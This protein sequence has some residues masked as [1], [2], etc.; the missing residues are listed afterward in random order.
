M[1]DGARTR[2]T[3]VQEQTGA[4]MNV[5]AESH[6]AEQVVKVYGLQGRELGRFEA[7]GQQLFRSERRMALFSGIFGLLV[8]GVV[9]ILRLTVLAV[10]SWL[11]IRGRI[12]PGHPRR[13]PRGDGR[14]RRAG[15]H[16]H[17]H[18]PEPAGHL[19]S[20]RTDRGDPRLAGRGERRW[21]APPPRCGATSASSASGSATAPD[22]GCSTMSTSPSAGASGWR[23]SGR[24]ARAS[25]PCCG[26]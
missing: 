18:R 6:L 9:T 5:A 2:S 24:R 1:G 10:G 7:A 20:A 26:C 19:G 21:A 12:D 17:H 13:L 15:H 4:L 3:V 11:V 8:N 25:P 14:A 23:S 16:A 22:R